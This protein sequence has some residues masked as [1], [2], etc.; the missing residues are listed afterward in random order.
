M[1]A[2]LLAQLKKHW[3]HE[4]DPMSNEF[5][6]EQI[7][8]VVR[9]AL[10]EALPGINTG[11]RS[12]PRTSV[13]NCALMKKMHQSLKSNGSTPVSVD[14]GT[15]VK[16]NEFAR[17]LTKC[18]QD[19]DVEALVL[20]GRIEFNLI[21][22]KQSRNDTSRKAADVDRTDA[23]VQGDE[24]SLES[25]VLT[26]SKILMLAKKYQRVVIGRKVVLTPLAMER[27]RKVD[28]EIVRQSL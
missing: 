16:L 23:G 6:K 21:N 17:D 10:R 3:K 9:D 18:L 15:R 14:V 13:A 12:T 27:A 26:E 8:A 20:S 1:C 19:K 28:L 11:N 22:G 25:G 24:H 5:S 4:C 7:R 2:P